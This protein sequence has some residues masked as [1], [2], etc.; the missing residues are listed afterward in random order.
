MQALNMMNN[1]FVT[2]RVRNADQVTFN[3]QTYRSTVYQ[4][5]NTAGMTN[6]QIVTELSLRTLSRMP[7]AAER[8]KLT[9]Y[10]TRLSRQAATESLQWALLNKADFLFNY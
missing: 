6:D 4:L 2:T 5:L 3:G 10:F 8:A 1:T 7:T 9:P